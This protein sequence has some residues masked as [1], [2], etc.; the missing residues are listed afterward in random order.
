MPSPE[1]RSA[2]PTANAANKDEAPAQISPRSLLRF[3]KR[4]GDTTPESVQLEKAAG[5]LAA[6]HCQPC[7]ST[8][9]PSIGRGRELRRGLKSFECYNLDPNFARAYGDRASA[10]GNLGKTQ[11][12][13]KI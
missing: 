12:A 10:Y 3:A 13:G 9:L 7:T 11:D 2:T 1:K 8:A 5:L 4:S 6:H